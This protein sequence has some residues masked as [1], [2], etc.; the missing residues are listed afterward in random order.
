[1][2]CA[3]NVWVL[4]VK[5]D[6]S[7]LSY[8]TWKVLYS[9]SNAVST[10]SSLFQDRISLSFGEADTP[11]AIRRCDGFAKHETRTPLQHVWSIKALFRG[12]WSSPTAVKT[13]DSEM[14]ENE[15]ATVAHMYQL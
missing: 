12:P 15:A 7:C 13:N 3:I 2:Q 5:A 1:M 6:V 10:H 4:S 8:C 9:V 11:Q 14:G